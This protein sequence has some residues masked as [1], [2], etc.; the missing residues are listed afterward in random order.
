MSARQVNRRELLKN[1]AAT[2][3]TAAGCGVAAGIFA[4]DA[5]GSSLP[6]R[7]P[8]AV[9]EDVT[10]PELL[11]LYQ[12]KADLEARVRELRALRATMEEAQYEAELEALLIDIA[13]KNR[14]IREK[15]GGGA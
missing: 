6:L 13:L 1:A 7:P 8:G 4:T 15:G 5:S 9:P 14:E 11:R 3:V 12:E 2:A 10:D